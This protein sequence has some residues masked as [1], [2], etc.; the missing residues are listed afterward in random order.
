[1][2]LGSA[3]SSK[4]VTIGLWYYEINVLCKCIISAAP[5]NNENISIYRGNHIISTYSIKYS[6]YSLLFLNFPVFV[7][8]YCITTILNVVLTF[9]SYILYPLL[10]IFIPL[11]YFYLLQI[12]Y[13]QFHNV[14]HCKRSITHI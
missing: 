10:Y 7:V 5:I 11:C 2:D 3:I 13:M 9:T 8:H 6:F 1:M 4:S 14:I 12:L